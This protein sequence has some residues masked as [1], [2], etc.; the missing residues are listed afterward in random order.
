MFK[1]TNQ[2]LCDLYVIL[3]DQEAPK[4]EPLLDVTV[5]NISCWRVKT[6]SE[7]LS[8]KHLSQKTFCLIVVAH[9]EKSVST[10]T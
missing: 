4:P 2:L 10:V 8:E 3:R 5:I 7:S 1:K 9:V 6:V